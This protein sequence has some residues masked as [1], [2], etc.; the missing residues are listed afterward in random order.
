MRN[1]HDF[2]CRR[3]LKSSWGSCR[4]SGR[5]DWFI[6]LLQCPPPPPKKKSIDS[7]IL[8]LKQPGTH[9]LLPTSSYLSFSMTHGLQILP[10][11]RGWLS[12]KTLSKATCL[13]Y[14]YIYDSNKLWPPRN[15]ASS[16]QTILRQAGGPRLGGPHDSTTRILQKKAREV[17]DV[18]VH[19]MHPNIIGR[20]L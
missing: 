20:K 13:A 14:I 7:G 19:L 10:P 11:V 9:L 16:G 12:W 5:E 8:P 18:S 3:H 4:S 15:A 1:A 2:R 6:Q 17:H